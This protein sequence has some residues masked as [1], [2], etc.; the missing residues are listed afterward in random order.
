MPRVSLTSLWKGL[1][2]Q[3]DESGPMET[4]SMPKGNFP[5]RI[6]LN[7]RSGKPRVVDS[8][9]AVICEVLTDE[10]G[11]AEYIVDRC[12]DYR[13]VFVRHAKTA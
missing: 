12:N 8:K 2:K 3:L 6:G 13:Q 7:D 5:W 1:L 9:N 4:S 10:S 11:V